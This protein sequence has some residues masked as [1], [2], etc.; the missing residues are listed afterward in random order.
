MS[1]TFLNQLGVI[2]VLMI[3]LTGL[4][5]L[6]GPDPEKAVRRLLLYLLGIYVFLLLALF[7]TMRFLTEPY[8][9]PFFQLSNLLAPSVLGITALVLLNWKRVFHTDPKTKIMAVSLG[10]V[11]VIL[12]GALWSS[13]L[14]PGYLI[15]PGALILVLGWTVGRWRD[16]LAVALTLFALSIF[17]GEYPL[18]TSNETNLLLGIFSKTKRTELI[19]SILLTLGRGPLPTTVY[20]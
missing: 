3:A 2:P 16:W 9:Q 20:D 19:S 6:R 10:L 13:Q 11:S 5:M 12:F 15:L 7:I 1:I 14:S 4:I 18:S 8:N 17:F